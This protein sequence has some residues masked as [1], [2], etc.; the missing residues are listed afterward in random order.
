MAWYLFWWSASIERKAWKV[1]PEAE[2]LYWDQ[3][4]IKQQKT[5]TPLC[6][7]REECG[8]TWHWMT[9]LRP[10]II[11][12]HKTSSPLCLH[13][14]EYGHTWHWMTFAEIWCHKTTQTVHCICTGKSTWYWMTFLRPGVINTKQAITVYSLYS[15]GFNVPLESRGWQ[16]LPA[17]EGLPPQPQGPVSGR[18]VWRVWPQHQWVDGRRHVKRHETNVCR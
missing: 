10:G 2:W 8:R 13:R 17:G 12:Q 6:L 3:V 5:S 1:I 14:K 11:K 18:T 4:S 15:P 7:H 9:L 16:Q